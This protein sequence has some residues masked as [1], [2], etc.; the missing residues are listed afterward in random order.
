MYVVLEWI[1]LLSGCMCCSVGFL[2][3]LENTYVA[4]NSVKIKSGIIFLLEVYRKPA[5]NTPV[6]LCLAVLN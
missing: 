2:L 4:N 3:L 6:Y 1:T 5:E